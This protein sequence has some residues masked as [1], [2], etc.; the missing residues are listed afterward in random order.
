MDVTTAQRMD[1]DR[2]YV[3]WD[4]E[5]EAFAVI[6]EVSGISYCFHDTESAAEN[7]LQKMLEKLYS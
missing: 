1:E 2:L 7:D 6:G 5:E 3:G 4:D